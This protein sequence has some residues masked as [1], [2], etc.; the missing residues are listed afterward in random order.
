MKGKWY[1]SGLIAAVVA[2][3]IGGYLL[4]DKKIEAYAAS[5]ILSGEPY[6]VSLTTALKETSLTDG[7]INVTDASGAK[8]DAQ[9]S[10]DEKRKNLIIDELKIGDYKVHIMKAAF[11]T[12]TKFKKDRT[13]DVK[14][15][16]QVQE[17]TSEA[18][19]KTYF[20]VVVARESTRFAESFSS[21]DMAS[22]E[23]KSE[24]ESSMALNDSSSGAS[25]DRH[26]GTNNQV[27][28]I[29]EGDI[30]VTDGTNI[31][32]IVDNLLVITDARNPAKM[33]VV[34]RLKLG[35]EVYPHQLMLHG[36]TLIVMYSDYVEN[37]KANGYYDGKTVTKSAFY[38]VTD[39]KN[40][41]LIR[42]LGQDG[43]LMGIRQSGNI[44]YTVTSQTPN[45]WLLREDSE[46]EL[47]PFTHD[48]KA[49]VTSEPLPIE[50][51]RLLPGSNEPSYLIIS[52]LDL[53]DVAQGKMTTESYLGSGGQMYMSTNAIYVT[54]PNYSAMPFVRTM[55]DSVM[56]VYS[57]DTQLY[58]IAVKGTTIDMTANT[59][60]KGNILNQFSMDEYNGYFRIATTEGDAWGADSD[61][62]NNLFIFDK[63]LKQVGEL[64]N[65]AR[66]ERIYS[67]RFMGDKAYVVTF[68]QVDP[69]FVIDVANPRAPKV[70][71]ELK[72]PGFSNYL[73]P[74]DERHLLG[75]GYDTKLKMEPG[76]KEPL[77]L[78]QGMKLSLFDV[79][80]LANPVEKDT[81]I[82]GGR[83]TYSDVQ[84]DHKALFRDTSK[85]YYGFPVTIY[86]D[87]GEYDVKYKGT[88]A[89]VYKVTVDGGIELAGDFVEPATADQ[90]YEEWGEMVQRLLYIDE[91]F[92][93]VSR[94]EIKS[95]NRNTFAP[96]SSVKLQMK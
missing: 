19:L 68:K 25:A 82:I 4:F 62:K 16:E 3:L 49:T 61:S 64:T 55:V 66:G 65:L 23:S 31:Y 77:V 80:D 7:S 21:D 86:E 18:D 84:H 51:I 78:T 63:D 56:P 27:D 40:P 69:L 47:R 26:S 46:V 22:E 53:K 6:V 50:H 29:E 75:I 13:F 71:G 94:S 59:T 90:Q 20:S 60:V 34:K 2:V 70:L 76:V 24:S 85:S 95:Y 83:G 89:L 5:I 15:V 9:L 39:A 38:D 74:I 17:I 54:A 14:V 79:T 73:H 87:A 42:E 96:I 91:A 32:S 72:I 44:L 36:K 93:T 8:V 67:A 81:V 12:R 28:G 52:A 41:K 43:G 92:Y 57:V 48:S 58:K 88:G 11:D 35:E 33:S 45:Y 37:K 1:A 30:I 10:L